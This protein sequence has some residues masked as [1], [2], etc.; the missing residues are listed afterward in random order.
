MQLPRI[1]FCALVP[2]KAVTAALGGQAD[3]HSAYGNGDEQQLPGVGKDVVDEIGCSW[4]AKDATRAR[5]WV[6]A[7]PVDSALA[8]TVIANGTTTPGCRTESGPAFGQP[9]STQ[10]CLLA[11]GLR[12]VRHA[13]LFG[14]T[15]LSCE[16][17]ATTLEKGL[18]TSRA[19]SWCVEVATALNQGAP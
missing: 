16:L 12:R 5:A 9:S 14:Q 1:E 4:T 11:G 18:L 3:A 2:S 10:L 15:W 6:F 19:D 7:R 17:A 13:G 8:R